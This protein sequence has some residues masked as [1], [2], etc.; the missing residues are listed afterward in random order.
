MKRVIVS[1][2]LGKMG[3]EVI[4]AVGK[5]TDMQVV[6]GADPAVETKPH[7]QYGE[8]AVFTNLE[9]PSLPPTPMWW[10]I[11]PRPAWSWRTSKPV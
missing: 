8:L 2:A 9:E 3:S 11:S 10:L 5:E 7:N 1:G 4:K 6:A